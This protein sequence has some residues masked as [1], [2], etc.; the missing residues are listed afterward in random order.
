M[1]SFRRVIVRGLIVSILA[2]VAGGLI[3]PTA[4]HVQSAANFDMTLLWPPAKQADGKTFT[5]EGALRQAA[6][7]VPGFGGFFLN[8]Q[9]RLQVYL[10]DPAKD[11]AAVRASLERISPNFPQ[12]DVRNI[13]ILQGQFGYMD[14]QHWQDEATVSILPMIKGVVFADNQEAANRVVIGVSSTDVANEVKTALQELGIPQKAVNIEIVGEPQLLD[15]DSRYRPV[16]GALAT[17]QVSPAG[18]VQPGPCTIGFIADYTGQGSGYVT[19]SHCTSAFAL[20][21]NDTAYEPTYTFGTGNRV[22]QEAIDPPIFAGGICPN[23]QGCLWADMAWI[24]FN[25]GVTGRRG[26]FPRTPLHTNSQQNF[27][28]WNGVDTYQIVGYSGGGPV[29]SQEVV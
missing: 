3:S 7:D 13:D 1:F 16:L 23:P 5:N 2:A 25:S 10:T 15:L 9:G 29:E 18:I 21:T 17:T 24:K 4:G 6:A 8:E 27:K 22:G 28:E 19:A 20:N 14:L 26:Y 11:A 12:V